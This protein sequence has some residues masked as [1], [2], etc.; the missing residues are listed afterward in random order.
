MDSSTRD[1][2]GRIVRRVPAVLRNLRSNVPDAGRAAHEEPLSRTDGGASVGLYE[3]PGCEVTYVSEGLE[4]CPD[5]GAGVYS[6]PNEREL[7]Y[8]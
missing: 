8:V 6:I 7:G 4:S 5:C 2:I 1:V 3:C